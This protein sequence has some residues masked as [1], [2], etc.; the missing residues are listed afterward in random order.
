[1][2]MESFYKVNRISRQISRRRIARMPLLISSG[3]FVLISIGC[4]V[5]I[6]SVTSVSAAE[7]NSVVDELENRISEL[8]SQLGNDHYSTRRQAQDQ[9]KRIGVPALDQLRLAVRNSDP[10]IATAARYLVKSSFTNW[11][12]DNDPLEVRRLL[13]NYGTMDGK[14]RE[15]AIRRLTLLRVDRGLPALLRIA[16]FEVSGELSR[17]AAISIF[18]NLNSPRINKGTEEQNR[19]RWEAVLVSASQGQNQACEWL[20]EYAQVRTSAKTIDPQYWLATVQKEVKLLAEAPTETSQDVLVEFTRFVAEQLAKSN[21]PEEAYQ[22]AKGLLDI[23]YHPLDRP[24][25]ARDL[26]VWALQN[27]FPRLVI[28]QCEKPWMLPLRNTNLDYLRAESHQRL[29]ENELA[30]GFASR[31]YLRNRED[32]SRDV[33]LYER[34][35]CGDDLLLRCQ[36]AWAEREFRAAIEMADPLERTTLD[37]VMQLSAV[38]VDGQDYAGAV[39]IM[40]PTM[41]RFEKEPSFASDLNNEWSSR[42]SRGSVL[43]EREMPSYTEIFRSDYLYYRAHLKINSGDLNTAKQDL[44]DAFKANPANIDVAITMWKNRGD[45]EWNLESE[46]AV[47]KA[48]LGFRAMI[49]KL[50]RLVRSTSPNDVATY[51]DEY[52]E[53]LNAYA[54]LLVCT[55]RELDV[56]LECSHLSCQLKPNQFGSLDTLARCYF[57][58]GKVKEAI[59]TQQVVIALKPEMRELKRALTEYQAANSK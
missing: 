22:V 49:P 17:R 30:E 5:P 25:K 38:L 43:E 59:E 6:A 14:G 12:N 50:E 20:K 31:A 53:T 39:E 24:S 29:G 56:A 8:I 2:V 9:L 40:K 57:K 36:Y 42:R 19:Q 23:E 1:M 21:R 35:K 48:I 34:K 11:T 45:E 46:N 37:M 27:G 32:T 58:V 28:E 15:D 10:Q 55:D 41:D 47:Q 18:W 52:A 3:Y 51:N 7:K 13:E 33:S 16:R 4:F 54:W 44:R 26:C